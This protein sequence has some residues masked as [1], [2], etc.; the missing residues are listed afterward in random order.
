[1][2]LLNQQLISCWNLYPQFFRIILTH[3]YVVNQV[4]LIGGTWC[5][6]QSDAASLSSPF[7]ALAHQPYSINLDQTVFWEDHELPQCGRFIYLCNDLLLSTKPVLI[8]ISRADIMTRWHKCGVDNLHNG[9]CITST[10]ELKWRRWQ[11]RCN[12]IFASC[13]RYFSFL[14]LETE[15]VLYCSSLYTYNY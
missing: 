14:S 9:Y 7:H 4:F 11:G 13:L 5:N 12:L 6:L 2:T 3:S 15:M 10:S 1:M 8:H